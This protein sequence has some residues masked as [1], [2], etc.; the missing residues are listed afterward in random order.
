MAQIW[1]VSADGGYMYS[2]NL[3]A[4]LRQALQP[5]QRF[6]QHCDAKDAT[7]LGL[8]Q[9]DT[10]NWNRYSKVA[11]K[12]RD[13]DENEVMPETKFT[14]SQRSLT[15]TEMGNSV[16]FSAKLD[17]FSTHDVK[18]VI[19]NVLKNDANDAIE[20]KAHAQFNAAPLKVGATSGTSTTAVTVEET[21]STITNNVA[22]GKGHIKAIVSEM[23]ERNIPMFDGDSYF[24]IAWPSTYDQLDDDLEALHIY[25][26]EG[27]RE[28]VNGERGRYQ[29]VRFLDQTGIPKGGAEDSTTWNAQTGTADLWN[30]GKSDWAFF[31]GEDTVAEA[32]V[33]P[34]EMRGKI[35]SDYGRAKGIAWYAINGFGIV[36]NDADNARI[37]KWDSA[38]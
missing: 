7:A 27:F 30:N 2:D 13:I 34:E 23:K 36:H 24:C 6:R 14:V 17:N 5:L 12:G 31:F 22:L 29:G 28:M 9:G 16:P 3:S 10:F 26:S 21:T 15:V 38:A 35:P 18:N 19:H 37:L 4:V 1:A 33:I 25:V 20:V 8:N 32:V 11:T